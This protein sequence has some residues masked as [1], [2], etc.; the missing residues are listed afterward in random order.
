MSLEEMETHALENRPELRIEDYN[1]RMS[2][3]Q[4][5][6]AMFDMLPG[7]KL[8]T[9]TNYSSDRFN[10]APNWLSTGFQLGMNI[11]GL[12]SGASRIDE[13]DKRGELARRQRLAMT[14]AVMT[15][16]HMAYIQF[17]NASQQMRLSREVARADRRLARLVASDTRFVSTDY[18]EA[19]RL[20]TKQLQSEMDEH[21]ARITLISAH[22]DVMHSVGLD[23]IPE[24]IRIPDIETLAAEIQR[25]TAAWEVDNG[26]LETPDDTPL[27]LLV[28]AM[29]EG[30]ETGTGD[31]QYP[32]S[33]IA[34]DRPARK[35][36]PN[37]LTDVDAAAVSGFE[38]ASGGEMP[39]LPPR[40]VDPVAV[41]DPDSVSSDLPVALESG[42]MSVVQLGVFKEE[43]RAL[44]LRDHLIRTS[45]GALYGVDVQVVERSAD[46]GSPLYYVETPTIPDR[47]IAQ[48]LCAS[49]RGLGQDCVSLT[50]LN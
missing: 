28:N 43:P 26:D 20:A 7:P 24:T 29:L 41:V 12:F 8:T 14:L 49:L 25:I 33:R 45:D 23:I 50:R 44:R 13:A 21:R 11:F 1:E 3:W 27:D 35:E 48:E 4:A 42:P 47:D 19:V 15:Q 22:S 34:A 38:P 37:E 31:G 17:R 9:G 2:V 39:P 10:L 36:L 6:E 40:A 46:D 30:G 32:G 16:T 18:F 5:R